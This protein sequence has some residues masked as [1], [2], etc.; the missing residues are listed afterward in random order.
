MRDPSSSTSS[1][2]RRARRD[3]LGVD[4]E[5]VLEVGRRARRA[6][7]LGEGGRRAPAVDLDARPAVVELD[8]HAHAGQPSSVAAVVGGAG[9]PDDRGGAVD[10]G[11]SQAER[12]RRGVQRHDLAAEGV[13]PLEVEHRARDAV[14]GAELEGRQGGAGRL[15]LA[16]A[17]RRD[18]P[19]QGE[20]RVVAA[21]VG[22]VGDGG[23]GQVAG[24]VR[25][26]AVLGEH[27]DPAEERRHR[28]TRGVGAE[29]DGVVGLGADRDHRPGRAAAGGDERLGEGG[30]RRV[31]GQ[32]ERHRD[33]GRLQCRDDGALAGGRAAHDD[34]VG[35]RLDGRRCGLAGAGLA[36]AGRGDDAGEARDLGRRRG[37]VG[38]AGDGGDLRDLDALRRAAAGV[39]EQH[40]GGVAEGDRQGGAVLDGRRRGRPGVAQVGAEVV[41]GRVGQHDGHARLGGGGDR[42]GGVRPARGDD[43]AGGALLDERRDGVAGPGVGPAVVLGDDGDV[44]AAEGEAA[45]GDEG[46]LGGLAPLRALGV[47]EGQHDADGR[48]VRHVDAGEGDGDAR[49]RG[50]AGRLV[51]G[52]DDG[53]GDDGGRG[54]D[55][56]RG[57][58]DHDGAAATRGPGR[59]GPGLG[60]RV[61]GRARR[62]V[63]V[64]H[65][66]P[67]TRNE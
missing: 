14:A 56:R 33:V 13:G 48:A 37:E 5:V 65:R 66:S 30:A 57:R 47:A 67:P 40:G 64:A 10:G 24:E 29:R 52:A 26:V 20:H 63:A 2:E 28:P 45:L 44:G 22:R 7:Q 50:V 23:E 53:H 35:G 42:A 18:R 8:Q 38:V 4:P 55:E 31:G 3:R 15:A 60:G 16:A 43:D 6:D 51:A 59:L 9:E 62:L 1:L 34:G 32:H 46:A 49:G 54:H 39:D 11:R 19:H 25:G 17:G 61:V 58:R 41:G 21:R 36:G 12:L 27:A